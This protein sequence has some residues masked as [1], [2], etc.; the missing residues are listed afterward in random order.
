MV[1]GSLAGRG[2]NVGIYTRQE[3]GSDCDFDGRWGPNSRTI[4]CLAQQCCWPILVY[5][6][7]GYGMLLG[8]DTDPHSHKTMQLM[9]KR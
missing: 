1:K 4:C 3:G 5:Q 6:S 7:R 8:V 9:Q 2:R